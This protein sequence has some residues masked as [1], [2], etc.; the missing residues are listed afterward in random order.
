MRNFQLNI[1]PHMHYNKL[2]MRSINKIIIA[3]YI[4][5][6]EDSLRALSSIVVRILR[7]E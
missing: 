1:G 2:S 4:Y 5:I 3:I 7:R 6:F